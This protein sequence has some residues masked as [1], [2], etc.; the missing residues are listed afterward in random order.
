VLSGDS[1]DLPVFPGDTIDAGRT[2]VKAVVTEVLDA[3]KGLIGLGVTAGA[4]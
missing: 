4:L 3:L 2:F 1:P